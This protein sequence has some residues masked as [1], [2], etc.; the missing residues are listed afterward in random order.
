MG[1]NPPFELRPE[2][3][4]RRGGSLFDYWS[5][6]DSNDIKRLGRWIAVARQT[7]ISR[8]RARSRHIDQLV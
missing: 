3:G 4:F 2:M 6:L 8:M 1:K 7:A 5:V